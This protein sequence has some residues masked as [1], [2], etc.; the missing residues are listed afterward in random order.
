MSANEVRDDRKYTTDH[1]W[2]QEKDG[3]LVVGITAF[4][5]GTKLGDI[6]LVNIDAAEGDTI[7]AGKP[8]GNHRER[9]KR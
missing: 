9:E 7:E 2:A 6:T 3:E 8:F 4:R 1:E 5:G